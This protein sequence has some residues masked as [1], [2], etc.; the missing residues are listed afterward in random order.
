VTSIGSYAFFSATGL[1]TLT[2]PSSITSIS[3]R[4]F[5]SA[6][7]LTAINVEP[8]NNDYSSIDGILFNKD[9]TT[10]IKYKYPEGNSKKTY[11]ISASVLSDATQITPNKA[12]LST[13]AIVGISIGAAVVA[14]GIIAGTVILIKNNKKKKNTT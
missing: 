1:T 11:T 9:K 6:I 4:A 2:I 14:G 7:N 13:G 10:L 12:F 8:A 3:L 5:S